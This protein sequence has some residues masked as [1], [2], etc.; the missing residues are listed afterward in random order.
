V[1]AVGQLVEA[2]VIHIDDTDR[3]L[4]V[5]H[6]RVILEST[7]EDEYNAGFRPGRFEVLVPACQW[8]AFREFKVIVL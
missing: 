1:R 4:P 2:C 6:D 7:K 3:G 5:A 8:L